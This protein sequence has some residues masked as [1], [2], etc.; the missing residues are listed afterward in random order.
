MSVITLAVGAVLAEFAPLFHSVRGTR[1]CRR[2]LLLGCC[3][4]CCYH[5]LFGIVQEGLLH[6]WLDLSWFGLVLMLLLLL[7]LLLMLMLLPKVL[8]FASGPPLA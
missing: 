5:H 6:V 3:C 7:L 8:P 2:L 4:C 1:L